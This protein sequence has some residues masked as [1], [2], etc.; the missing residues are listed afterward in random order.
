[1]PWEVR[2][3]T[4]IATAAGVA[5][6]ILACLIGAL[7]VAA[8]GWRLQSL[9]SA[10]PALFD[11]AGRFGNSIVSVSRAPRPKFPAICFQRSD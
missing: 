2:F 10:I 5:A 3:R 8:C 6:L 11:D 1:M 4:A 9:S 7:A